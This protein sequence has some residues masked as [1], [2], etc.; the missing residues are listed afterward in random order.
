M[1]PTQRLKQ[2]PIF[3]RCSRQMAKRKYVT[4]MIQN[5]HKIG[6]LSIWIVSLGAIFYLNGHTDEMSSCVGDAL[7]LWKQGRVGGRRV[8]VRE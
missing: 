6:P 7:S 1:S 5:G 2:T 3:D 4:E 8:G